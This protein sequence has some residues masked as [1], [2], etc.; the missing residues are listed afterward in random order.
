VLR[1]RRRIIGT[2]GGVLVAALLAGCGVLGNP[3]TNPSAGVTN[4]PAEEGEGSP[5][6]GILVTK[7]VGKKAPKIGNVVV[8]AKGWIFYRFDEDSAK[9]SNSNCIDECAEK[10]PPIL[11]KGEDD[12][13]TVKGINP[14]KVGAVERNDGNWQLTIGGW[15]MYRYV[16]DKKA[17]EWKGQGVGGSWFVATKDGKKNLNLLPKAKPSEDDSSSEDDGSVDDGGS[18]G[19]GY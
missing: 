6:A 17:G 7:V 19:G 3:G 12:L 18:Y 4:Q 8:D 13:P 15:P 11:V 10:W 2:A 9:P 16:G 14:D 5:A 1:D